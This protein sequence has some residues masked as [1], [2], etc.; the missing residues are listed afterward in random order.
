MN[1]LAP[2][3]RILGRGPG[4]S[5]NLTAE[6]AQEAMGIILRGKCA[7]EAVGGLLMLMRYRGEEPQEIEGF[8]R[9]FR[10][11]LPKWQGAHPALDWPTYAAGRS[12]GL[13]WFLL[14]ARIVAMAGHSV[15]LH[16][17]NSYQVE[18]ADVRSALPFVGIPMAADYA[19]A[20]RLLA[21]GQ[22]AYLPL[23]NF[24]PQALALL[25]LRDVLGLRSCINTT[26]R[27]MN[28][29]TA[30]AQV[31]GVFHPPYLT[32]QAEASA[33][34]GQSQLS[35][36]K[37]GGGEFER[38]PAK[39]IA[40]HGLRDGQLWNSTA[41]PILDVHQRL[42]ETDTPHEAEYLTK[43]WEGTHAD[44]YAEAIVLG[45]AAVALETVGAAADGEGLALAQD[46]WAKRAATVTA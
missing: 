45:T 43:F 33:L 5:R 36:L 29:A 8:V 27:V 30:D 44:P 6:E 18:G 31:Q 42:S 25:K 14:S 3:V 32:L 46:L 37:G 17:W 26:C 35:V 19:D 1:Q 11:T 15:L 34:L 21:D 4:R 38:N 28:P 24:A 23:E 10:A 22:I 40:L 12:R 7:P 2:F 41:K 13:P 39:P 16:G 9:A 20:N